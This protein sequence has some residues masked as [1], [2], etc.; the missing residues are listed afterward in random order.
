MGVGPAPTVSGVGVSGDGLGVRAGVMTTNTGV[1][2]GCCTAAGRITNI[3]PHNPAAVIRITSA[4]ANS[5]LSGT[6]ARWSLNPL[7]LTAHSH[8]N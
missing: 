5:Q 8:V 2:V 3:Y 4:T 1:T 6:E 7:E